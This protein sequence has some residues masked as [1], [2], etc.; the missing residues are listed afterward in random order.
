MNATVESHRFQAEVEELLGL[1][2][3]SLYKHREIFL[4]E[5]VSNASDA[6]DKLRV[7]ALTRPELGD[8][9]EGAIRIEVDREARTLSV[10]DDG[11]GMSRDELVNN[12]GTIARSGTRAFV[13]KMRKAGEAAPE[14]IGQFGV[15]FYSSFIVA[16]EVVVETRRAG[17]ASGW[18]WK[19][20]GKAEFSIE[21]CER[22]THG[23]RITL[24]LKQ[25]TSEDEDDPSD[26]LD[27]HRL[28]DVVRRYSDFVSYKIEMEVEREGDDGKKERRV[29]V[30][31]SRR[32]LWTRSKDDVK[33]EEYDEFYRRIAHDWT[34]PFEVVHFKAEGTFEYTALLF[35]PARR[36]N[37]LFEG[38][39]PKAKL[40]LYVKRVLIM[41]ECLDLLPPWMRFVRGLV[42]A[43]DLPLNVS[44]EV[45]QHNAQ[46]RAIQKRLVQRVVQ[47]L[48]ARLESDR[49][50]YAK[51]FE[52]FGSLLKE[53]I[54]AG[55]DE[56]QR[57]SKLLLFAT[58][59]G[60]EPTTLQEYVGRMK[61]GQDAIYY[62]AGESREKLGGSPHLEAFEKRGFEVLYFVDPI[63]EWL[64]TRLD[65][66]DGKPLRAIDRA[67]QELENA[68]EKEARE[69][70]ERDKRELLAFLEEKLGGQVKSVRFSTRLSDSAAVLV[71]DEGGL[72]P[73]MERILRAAQQAVPEQKRVLELN[74]DHP[75]TKRIEA[76]FASDRNGSDLADLVE[77]LHGQAQLSC[78]ETPAE[79]ARFAK[80]VSRLA[81]RI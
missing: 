36:P 34:S 15:G 31:N 25:R 2:V 54:Y 4:R 8:V 52:A 71:P 26:F 65:T 21:P 64:V 55:A 39:Q 30:L 68:S 74:P 47:A 62:L 24:H 23:T 5:L 57:L 78:G 17:E 9:G 14:L 1:V 58:T 63:D 80:L 37:D 81:A 72:S 75:L 22:A 76:G 10:S 41:E 56:D 73:H 53:G 69:T 43:P 20:R 7:E 51:F 44:R 40:A 33:R 79:P 19:S 49:A 48:A 12:L 29:E 59:H 16:D 3:H 38:A 50:E 46:V 11:I 70:L 60:D 66:F 61:S 27:E 28:R 18:R 67:G 77:L 13:E 42:D 45:L 6:L 35:V 32:P